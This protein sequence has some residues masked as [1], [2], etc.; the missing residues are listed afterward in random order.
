MPIDRFKIIINPKCSGSTP[1]AI[2]TGINTGTRIV[3][4]GDEYTN[5][6]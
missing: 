5:S 1:K 3:Q 2:A 6:K 4:S